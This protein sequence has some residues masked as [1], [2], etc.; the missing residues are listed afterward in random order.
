M[1]QPPQLARA[2]RIKRS[3][4]HPVVEEVRDRCLDIHVLLAL[5]AF[6]S[7]RQQEQSRRG[8]SLGGFRFYYLRDLIVHD[9]LI[10]VCRF[11]GRIERIYVEWRPAGLRR[12]QPR[13]ICPDCGKSY[14]KLY[15]H[16]GKGLAPDHFACRNCHG[17]GYAC[18]QCSS[19]QRKLLRGDRY[20]FDLEH[21]P[22]RKKK[23]DEI[24]ARRSKLPQGT[25]SKRLS[26]WRVRTPLNW[27][28]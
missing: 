17:L 27:L 19:R 18:Q 14:E 28:S 2:C 24:K 26:S 25:L 16:A 10:E 5:E 11:D 3:S 13:L 8:N 9:N 6:P 4:P 7:Q 21:K 12:G 1:A 15:F 20:D 23:N 22:R